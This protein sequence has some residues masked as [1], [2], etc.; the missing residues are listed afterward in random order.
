[1]DIQDLE[2]NYYIQRENV[3]KLE[4]LGLLTNI[5]NINGRKEYDEDN[6]H[7]MMEMIHLMNLGFD[8]QTLV[9]YYTKNDMQVYIL[10]K[11]RVNI[12]KQVHSFQK[13]LDDIDY[14]IY[15]KEKAC[16]KE[17]VR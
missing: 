7:Q 3:L 13:K 2:K 15:K 4:K 5:P 14:M 10:K 6:L 8:D 17:K 11:I 12:L 16:Q 9:D 1:M